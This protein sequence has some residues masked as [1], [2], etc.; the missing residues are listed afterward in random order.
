MIRLA[1][2]RSQAAGDAITAQGDTLQVTIPAHGL[3]LMHAA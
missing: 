1:A 3:R 2:D